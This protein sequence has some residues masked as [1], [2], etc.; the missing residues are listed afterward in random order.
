MKKINKISNGTK[1][2]SNKK[3]DLNSNNI[4]VINEINE[5]NNNY[6]NNNINI[7]N[8]NRNLSESHSLI[9]KFININT[10]TEK[11]PQNNNNIHPNNIKF[12][13]S[14]LI[15]PEISITIQKCTKKINLKEL[16]SLKIPK[17]K[18]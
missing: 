18:Y 11:S 2:S 14:F 16:V 4:V 6:F 17:K 5:I 13:P 7:N 8:N 3:V 10:P 15:K 9:K 1:S 12:R